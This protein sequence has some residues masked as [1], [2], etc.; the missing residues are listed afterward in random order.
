MPL[1]P[2][3][4]NVTHPHVAVLKANLCGRCMFSCI[5]DLGKNLGN[6]EVTALTED[7]ELAAV[8][9]GDGGLHDED[10]G[11]SLWRQIGVSCGQANSG[12]RPLRIHC[13]FQTFQA[14][15][16]DPERLH[17]LLLQLAARS[18]ATPSLISIIIAHASP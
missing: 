10:D 17:V 14:A 8:V 1:Y 11:S 3:K 7:G 6:L 13:G 5:A 15:R 18:M 9:K 2:M 16:V 4:N 12:M